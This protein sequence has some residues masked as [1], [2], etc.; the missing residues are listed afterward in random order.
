MPGWRDEEIRPT[1]VLDRDLDGEDRQGHYLIKFY[2]W[3][4]WSFRLNGKTYNHPHNIIHGWVKVNGRRRG[5]TT[6]MDE[7]EWKI[8]EASSNNVIIPVHFGSLYIIIC[9]FSSASKSISINGDRPSIWTERNCC[10]R[11]NTTF[12]SHSSSS[13]VYEHRRWRSPPRGTTQ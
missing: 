13:V 12:S 2:L 8:F 6:T 7:I 11:E 4:D 3:I 5:I 10:G 9:S 1:A